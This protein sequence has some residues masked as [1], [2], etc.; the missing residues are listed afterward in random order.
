MCV[1]FLLSFL[2]IRLL[3]LHFLS[4]S[5]L[6]MTN[7]KWLMEWKR[8]CNISTLY[9]SCAIFQHRPQSKPTQCAIKIRKIVQQK[10]ELHNAR[11]CFKDQTQCFLNQRDFLQF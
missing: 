7:F 9:L 11:D 3:W 2:L 4:A 8:I 5:I 10:Y 1:A 6:H